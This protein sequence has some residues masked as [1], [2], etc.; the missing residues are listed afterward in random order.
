MPFLK[1]EIISVEFEMPHSGDWLLHP[2]VI[3][4][5]ADVYNHDKCY[6]CAMMSSNGEDDRFSFQLTNSMLEKPGNTQNSQVRCHLITYVREV[7]IKQAHPYNLS[8][9][10]K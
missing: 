4:S 8:S 2:G 3:I 10:L 7:Y 9:I 1:G 6:V 5:C